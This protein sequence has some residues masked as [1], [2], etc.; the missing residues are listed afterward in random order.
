MF[1]NKI[2]REIRADTVRENF[3]SFMYDL[4]VRLDLKK[5]FC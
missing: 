2:A 3:P 4:S 1:L 5:N